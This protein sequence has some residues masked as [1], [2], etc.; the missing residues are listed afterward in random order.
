VKLKTRLVSICVAASTLTFMACGGDDDGVDVIDAAMVAD[1]EPPPGDAKIPDGPVGELPDAAPDATPDAAP[2]AMLG[3]ETCD[4]DADDNGDGKIDCEDPLCA[5]SFFPCQAPACADGQT[6]VFYHAADLPKLVHGGQ[7]TSSTITVPP[8]GAVINAA[9]KVSIGHNYITDIVIKLTSP[10]NTTID[11]SS[12][13]GSVGHNYLN[14]VFSDSATTSVVAGMAPFSGV[15]RPEEPFSRFNGQS[16]AGA[17]RMDVIESYLDSNPSIDDGGFASYDLMLCVCTD[18]EVGPNCSDTVD[19]DHD[20]TTD[21]A[22]TDCATNLRCIPETA[23]ADG[24]D[25]DLD[26]KVDCLDDQCDGHNNCQ[27]GNETSCHDAFDNDGDAHTDCT[28]SDCA[29]TPLC[30]IETNCTDHVDND[31]DGLTDCAD[32]GCFASSPGCQTSESTCDDDIDNDGDGLV[33]CADPNCQ[34]GV[35]CAVTACPAGQ[36]TLMLTATG[37]PVAIPDSST[38]GATA[39]ITVPTTGTVNRVIATIGITHTYVGDLS[40]GLVAPG[41]TSPG[42]SLA[43]RVGSS[44][45]NFTD[46]I[47]SDSAGTLITDIASMAPYTGPFKPDGTLS[48]LAGHALAGDWKLYAEDHAFSDTGNITKFQLFICYTP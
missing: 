45:D 2:D 35:T 19:N 16:S 42:V 34:V 6:R 10:E 38:V 23:C 30:L 41:E 17:W 48:T 4:N 20:G 13:N 27:F 44:G 14:T 18:C 47:F 25:N 26:A 9:T 1:A 33:D 43:N 21:C 36:Q 22:D 3:P 46:T 15:F 5:N 8:G 37:V 12:H 24:L 32:P 39:N 11:L 7:T 40:V 28:D 31:M 29:T